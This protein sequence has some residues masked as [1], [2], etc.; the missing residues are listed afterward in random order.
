MSD[1]TS[2]NIKFPW[3]ISSRAE[4][5]NPS[6]IRELL[7]L[8]ERPGVISF[9]G[10]LPS[11]DTFPTAI[12]KE[13]CNKVLLDQ[14][15]EALQYSASEGY[16]P[17]REMIA[18][19]LPWNV[20]SSQVLITNG[21]Q[22]GLDL[23]S[24]VLIDKNS[25]ILVESPTY[26]GALMAFIPMQPKFESMLCNNEGFDLE[27]LKNKALDARFMY[28]VPNFQN[29]TGNT[30]TETI[31]QNLCQLSVDIGLPIIEDNPYGDLWFDQPPPPTLTN[32]NPEGCIYLGSFSKVLSP[33]LRLG[34][35]VVPKSI[36]PKMLQA[37]QAA[38]LHSSSFSQRVIYEVIRN[39]FLD[40]HIPNIRALY[41]S[42]RDVMLNALANN[43]PKAGSH[44]DEVSWNVPSGGMFLWMRLPKKMR[45][46][47]LL[48]R[49]M[50]SGVAFVPGESF[51]TEYADQRSIRL[52]FVSVSADKIR[53]GIKN[54]ASVITAERN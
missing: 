4:L 51:F 18:D 48:P 52:S 43:F 35:M 15:H 32:R 31:R 40:T 27:D 38:D 20:D 44:E 49:A 42:Q 46:V 10:G 3:K 13:A 21:S 39:G 16:Q 11:P 7:K 37:K 23:V 5:M 28:L 17:L 53:E 24:K 34:Y 8:T 22:Q 12:F 30:L 6:V 19:Y 33:G 1:I 45:A 9:A 14:P 50:A 36:F 41:K 2:A 25:K 47:D 54:L 29:P 26:L